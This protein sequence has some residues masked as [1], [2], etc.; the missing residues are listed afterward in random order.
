MKTGI[1]FILFC[2]AQLGMAQAIPFADWLTKEI[3]LSQFKI[4]EAMSY[5][6][7]TPGAIIASPSKS[8]PD[9]YYHWVRDAGLIVDVLV[10]LYIKSADLAEKKHLERRINDY[11]SFSRQ[12][13]NSKA[14]SGYGEPKFYVN[15]T[16]YGLKWDDWGRPQNDGPALRALALIKW[17]NTQDAAYV[18]KELYN[19]QWPA[20][21]LI[22][23]DLEYVAAHW[24]DASF[25]LWE[26]VLGDHFF[27]RFVQRAA[28][29]QG[30]QLAQ[31]LGD[32]GAS[33]W[34]LKQAQ[35]IEI[36]LQEF[37]KKSN[38]F[39]P[40]TINIKGSDKLKKSN[41]DIAIILAVLRSPRDS[42]LAL[43][44]PQ[45]IGTLDKLIIEFKKIYDVNKSSAPGVAIGRYPE[46]V[47]DGEK[48]EGGNPWVLTTLAAAELY[49]EL[50]DVETDPVKMKSW[51]TRGDDFFKRVQFHAN[52]DGSLSEQIQRSTGHMVSAHNLTWNYAAILTASWARERA[53]NK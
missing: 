6:D 41:L 25:D 26:E 34:Y 14:L 23:S 22:K 3:P 17:A 44:D 8:N 40:A 35:Q 5:P 19:P 21:S 51:I 45:V 12:N 16:P 15:G 30:A 31:R 39:I 36:T 11:I 43:N 42:F 20:N 46:D 32:V 48:S 2:Y 28:L 1:C 47:Y 9:Y 38:L 4:D 33:D 27:T 29:V 37:L 13:Q 53:L 7:M 18:Q 10:D 49:Y 50:A 52:E 24:R